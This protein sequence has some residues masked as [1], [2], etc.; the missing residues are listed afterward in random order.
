MCQATGR[1]RKYAHW[2]L[3]GLTLVS[4]SAADLPPVCSLEKPSA[5]PGET[6]WAR[7][8]YPSGSSNTTYEWKPAAGKI[9]VKSCAP[10]RPFSGICPQCSLECTSC[11]PNLSPGLTSSDVAPNCSF[12]NPPR[13]AAEPGGAL[14]DPKQHEGRG[15][16]HLRCVHLCVVSG[17]TGLFT[18]PER[19]LAVLSA[20]QNLSPQSASWRTTTRIPSS[21]RDV[22]AGH[23]DQRHSGDC[24]IAA[25]QLRLLPRH[26]DSP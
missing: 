16:E 21:V 7:A 24:R 14:L 4:M 25:C 10:A 1:I 5:L 17:R 26:G 8:Q 3:L 18:D 19:Y 12:W 22:C 9:Q 23:H 6:I 15:A 2:T 13:S 11:R 20:W